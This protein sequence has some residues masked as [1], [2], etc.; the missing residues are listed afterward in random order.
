MD[1]NITLLVSIVIVLCAVIGGYKHGMVKEITGVVALAAGLL[2]IALGIMLFSSFS[3][4]E[5][6]NTVYTVI[7][8]VLFGVVYGIVKFLLRSA[9]AVSRLPIL[10]FCNSVLGAGVGFCKGILVLWILFLLCYHVPMGEVNAIVQAD[11]AENTI[12][13]I[14]YQYNIFARWF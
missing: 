13:K 9:K 10:D 12:L 11:I 8:L 3:R 4:G 7:L 6:T 14:I 5:V 1:I 2:V